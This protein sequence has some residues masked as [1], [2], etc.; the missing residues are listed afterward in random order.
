MHVNILYIQLFRAQPPF[1]GSKMAQRWEARCLSY[2]VTGPY[3][4]PSHRVI[5]RSFPAVARYFPSADSAI[6]RTGPLWDL[7]VRN[8]RPLSMSH[9]FTVPSSLALIK[10]FPSWLTRR[11]LTHSECPFKVRR[12]SRLGISQNLMVQSRLPEIMVDPSGVNVRAP[13][14]Y[15]IG[16]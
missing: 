7:M 15:S 8:W 6:P 16:L 13:I 2:F 4:P 12:S 14:Q 9:I 10:T 3:S 1:L 5:I 11:F